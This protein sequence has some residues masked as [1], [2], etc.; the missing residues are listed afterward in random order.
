[1]KEAEFENNENK[2]KINETGATSRVAPCLCGGNP[3]PGT[4]VTGRDRNENK[5]RRLMKNGALLVT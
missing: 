5:S 1:M 3:S 2:R 4:I